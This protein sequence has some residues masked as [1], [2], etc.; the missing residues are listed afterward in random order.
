[1]VGVTCTG[2]LI[3]QL[4][5]SIVQLALPTL[6]DAFGVSVND[7]RWVAIAY[8]LA[9]ASCLPIFGRLCE[10]FGRK[11][12]YLTGFAL[13]TIASL[14]CGWADRLDWLIAFRVL[15]GV[16]GGLLGA[17]SIAILVAS[18]PEASRAHA[19]GVFTAA[20]L[21]GVSTGPLAGGI[22]L[23]ALGW[24]WIFWAAV[25]FGI[26]AIVSGWVVLPRSV[27]PA[28]EERFDWRGS[29]LLMP[30]L[31][32]AI[33]ALNQASVWPLISPAMI[34]CIGSAALL[35][36][37][38]VRQERRAGWPVVD[39]LLF[40]SRAFSAGV[41]C[42][43]LGYALLYGMLFLMSFALVHGLHNSALL[44]G[45]KLATIPV[46]M[47]IAAPV[48]IVLSERFGSRRLGIW[49]MMLCIVAI[50]VLAFMAFGPDRLIPRLCALALFGIGLGLFMAPN[51]DATIKAAPGGHVATAGALVNL[52]RVVGSCVGISSASS[53]MS[54][55]MQAASGPV[56]GDPSSPVSLGL[57][58]AV[59]SSLIMLAV[60]CRGDR[61]CAADER[62]D[63]KKPV[64]GP[65]LNGFAAPSTSARASPGR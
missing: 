28:S 12:L 20:Q 39:L 51:S 61:R 32:L 25:P 4:D 53:L 24:R 60:F 15:Q 45:I 33:L 18:V 6:K 13:F 57:L 14:L 58:E 21:I 54:W 9:F 19:I 46:A 65:T 27:R 31:T 38:F 43:V 52:A 11:L 26:A 29:L 63:P 62:E 64:I 36:A 8:L 3:G 10:M 23:D 30:T 22:L 49:A 48:G 50:L 34:A 55:R 47:G 17:N 2:A 37:L 7:V 42:A 56:P 5:A 59:E 35:L 40:G 44:A 41:V 16:G 1:M